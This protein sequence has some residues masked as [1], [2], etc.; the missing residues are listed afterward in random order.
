MELTRED[1]AHRLFLLYNS[2][3]P[4]TRVL[5]QEA[6][7][8]KYKRPYKYTENRQ[9]LFEELVTFSEANNIH[10]TNWLVFLFERRKWQRPPFLSRQQLMSPKSLQAYRKEGVHENIRGFWAFAKYKQTEGVSTLTLDPRKDIFRSVEARKLQLVTDSDICMAKTFSRT[11]PTY[12]FHPRSFPC[13]GCKMKEKC[14]QSLIEMM[15]PAIVPLRKGEITLEQ[16]EG[17]AGE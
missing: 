3:R 4:I 1:K 14:K 6:R 16:Y 8:G 7:A 11:D 5:M 2:L 15:G 12:G 10:P 13:Q 17:V 9:A